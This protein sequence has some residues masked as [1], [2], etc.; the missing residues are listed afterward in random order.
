MGKLQI[1]INSDFEFDDLKLN[2]AS[3][4]IKASKISELAYNM[5]LVKIS[6]PMLHKK[7][8]AEVDIF[9]PMT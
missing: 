8:N 9:L 5:L 6:N 3:K 2:L 4:C 1:K 7:F